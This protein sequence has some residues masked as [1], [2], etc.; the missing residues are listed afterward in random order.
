MTKFPDEHD[1]VIKDLDNW[2]KKQISAEDELIP[3]VTSGV[4]FEI[5]IDGESAWNNVGEVTKVTPPSFKDYIENMAKHY[6]IPA[7]MLR[8]PIP[9]MSLA[10]TRFIDTAKEFSRV[11][12]VKA[13]RGTGVTEQ[14]LKILK[15]LNA[16][17]NVEAI[18]I[19]LDSIG[20][21]AGDT[22]DLER[23]IYHDEL[24]MLPTPIVLTIGSHKPNIAKMFDDIGRM[25]VNVD[26]F[27]MYSMNQDNH[28]DGWYRMF[29]KVNHRGKKNLR[30]HN[31]KNYTRGGK[32]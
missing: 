28:F 4:T 17:D 15:R 14:M 32:R 27:P 11:Y 9:D 22:I 5:K 16:D 12:M 19:D 29:E 2:H 31:Y 24:P 21:D 3:L 8:M 10:Q 20:G 30:P 1:K 6:E 23:L 7:H 18:V 13:R 26:P 25:R